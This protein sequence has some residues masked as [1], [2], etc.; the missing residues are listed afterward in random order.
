MFVKKELKVHVHLHGFGNSIRL[1]KCNH[2]QNVTGVI[3]LFKINQFKLQSY[4]FLPHIPQGTLLSD[5]KYE[6]QT[7]KEVQTVTERH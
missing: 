1:Y 5:F 6:N 4:C 7:K 2:R 3:E